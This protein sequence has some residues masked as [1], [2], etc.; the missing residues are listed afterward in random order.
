MNP[1]VE[2][3]SPPP[4]DFCSST[5]PMRATT[6]MR[7]MTTMTVSID[8]IRLRRREAVRSP[9]P[10]LQYRKLRASLHDPPALF[11]DRLE[12]RKAVDSSICNDLASREAVG[13]ARPENRPMGHRSRILPDVKVAWLRRG[14]TGTSSA[15]K[16]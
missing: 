5:T 13:P 1:L 14:S 9:N 7:W 10:R 3:T 6:S 11:Q 4:S 12:H 15:R 8:D 2:L 16:G